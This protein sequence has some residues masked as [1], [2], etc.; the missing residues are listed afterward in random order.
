VRQGAQ[1]IVFLNTGISKATGLP[2]A[3][4]AR[5][6]R[7][8]TGV[9]TLVV[10]WDEL[11]TGEIAALQEE[12]AGGHAGE[13]ETS[14]NLYLQPGKVDMDLAVRD[15]GDGGT[16]QDYAGYQPGRQAR[17]PA[18]PAFSASGVFGDATLATAEKGE[19][20]LAV[21]TREWLEA[22]DGFSRVPLRREP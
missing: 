19:K 2:I 1:R 9:P 3:I 20:A 10:S 11:E 6:I 8:A 21:L 14:I 4:A 16:E 12:S 13:I 18:D 7:V 5:E 22:L 15:Y 17:D